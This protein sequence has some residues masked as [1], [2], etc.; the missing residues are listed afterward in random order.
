MTIRMVELRMENG[1]TIKL[2]EGIQNDLLIT[3]IIE[4]ILVH[5]LELKPKDVKKQAE[6]FRDLLDEELKRS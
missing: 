4:K 6:K 2:M 5:D 3:G 1:K